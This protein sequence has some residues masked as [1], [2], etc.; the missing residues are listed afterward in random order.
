MDE[1]FKELEEELK[2]HDW[3]YE[4]SD[5]HTIWRKGQAEWNKI[6]N[7]IAYCSEFDKGEELID[8]L[9]AKYCPFSRE[10]MTR[11]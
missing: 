6:Q 3:Y 4:W 1:M 7:R 8:E 5:S 2:N 10:D 11:T 9:W